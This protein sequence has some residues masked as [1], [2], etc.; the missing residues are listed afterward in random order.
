MQN[1]PLLRPL[2]D[3]APDGVYPAMHLTAAPG[4][5]LLHLFTLSL[6][7][8]KET[9]NMFKSLH[10]RFGWYIFCGTFR[11]RRYSSESPNLQRL[12]AWM[13]GHPVLWSPDF[14]LRYR[15]SERP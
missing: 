8:G 9:I 5:L 4:G 12:P 2:F 1:G 3:L 7:E 11:P 15:V 13:P 10:L 14:P 6:H